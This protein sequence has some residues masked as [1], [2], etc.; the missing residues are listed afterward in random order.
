[1][2]IDPHT[3]KSISIQAQK[4]SRFRSLRKDQVNYNPPH[5]IQFNFDSITEF[6]SILMPRHNKDN[7]QPNTKTK[8]LST[9]TQKTCQFRCPQGIKPSSTPHVEIL[10]IL[11]T[12]TKAKPRS[13]LTLKRR[14]FRLA[15]QNQVNFYH[16][17]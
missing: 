6:K 9:L 13:T 10:S 12:H 16:P 4:T 15:H 5:K 2:V 3:T 7:F 1:M 11:T 8:S 14:D 17:H